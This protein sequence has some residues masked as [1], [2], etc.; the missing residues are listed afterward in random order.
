MNDETK[1]PSPRSSWLRRLIKK[2]TPTPDTPEQLVSLLQRSHESQV[3]DADSLEIMEGAIEVADLHARDIMIARSQ[4][5]V[6]KSTDGLDDIL[7]QLIDTGHSR[8]PVIGDSLDD[9]QGIL[10]AKD[11]NI[12]LRDG[13]DKFD[14]RSLLRT[15]TVIPESK[16]ISILLRDFREQ[17]YHMAIV[18]DEYGSIAGLITIE[19]ILEEIV[20]EIEDETDEED[21]NSILKA[22]RGGWIVEAA[23]EIDEFND[24]FK[25]TISD[26]E[27]DTLG[28]ILNHSFGHLPKAGEKTDIGNLCFEIVEADNRRIFKVHVTE[29]A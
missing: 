5:S 10:L 26:E 9:V 6:I 24:Y 11:L 4:M 23:I 15:A 14:L 28:G 16:R 12:Y 7:S 17:R 25:S 3:I 18:A 19:D 27:Y 13:V 22:E 2:L 21:H 1:P 29:N 8:F 20:G